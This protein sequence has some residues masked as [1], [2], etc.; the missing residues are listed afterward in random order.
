MP[1]RLPERNAA[2][3][4]VYAGMWMACR[5]RADPGIAIAELK[6]QNNIISL[7]NVGISLHI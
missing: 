7:Y 6:A 1:G 3:D 5:D 4:K 2:R